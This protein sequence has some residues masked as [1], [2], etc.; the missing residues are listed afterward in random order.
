[1]N[2]SNDSAKALQNIQTLVNAYVHGTIKIST[3][4]NGYGE[5]PHTYGLDVIMAFIN[6]QVIDGLQDHHKKQGGH[7]YV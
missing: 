1:M 6:N 5:S 7:I 3:E 4:F 2:Q